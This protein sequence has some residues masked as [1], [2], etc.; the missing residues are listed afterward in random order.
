MWQEGFNPL[1]PPQTFPTYPQTVSQVPS[2]M[3]GHQIPMLDESDNR[4]IEMPDL[5]Q[6]QEQVKASACP[7][8][9]QNLPQTGG[10]DWTIVTSCD[11][12]MLVETQDID[13]LSAIIESF[14][15]AE[16]TQTEAELFP[17]PLTRKFFCILQIAVKYLLEC[18]DTLKEN[19]EESDRMNEELKTKIKKLQASLLRSKEIS[20]RNEKLKDT[21]E[22]CV[23]CGRRF[24]TIKYLDGH[25]QRRHA[26]L[27][28]AWRSLRSGELQGMEHFSE[29]LENLRQEVA[30]T[31]MELERQAQKQANKAPVTHIVSHSDEQVQLMKQL[32][33][34]QDEIIQQARDLEEK[35]MSFRKEMRNQLDDAVVALQDAQKQLDFQATRISQIPSMPPPSKEPLQPD[36]LGQSLTEQIMKPQL[37]R[38][39]KV[40]FD[41]DNLIK[42][43][44][45]LPEP[46]PALPKFDLP[47]PIKPEEQTKQDN[48]RRVQII[49]PTEPKE[50]GDTRDEEHKKILSMI[51]SGKKEENEEE[52]KQKA[53]KLASDREQLQR[54]LQQAK[55]LGEHRID[56][57]AD[58]NK[59]QAIEIIM[60]D[61]IKRVDVTLPTLKRMRQHAPL[62]VPFVRKKMDPGNKEY[63]NLYIQL[64]AF[65]GSEAPINDDYQKKLFKDRQTSFPLVPPIPKTQ[66]QA[67]AEKRKKEYAEKQLMKQQD[68]LPKIPDEI[69]SAAAKKLPYKQRISRKRPN[70]LPGDSDVEIVDRMSSEYL[71][72][73]SVGFVED[74]DYYKRMKRKQGN[75]SDDDFAEIQLSETSS[76]IEPLKGDIKVLNISQFAQEIEEEESDDNFETTKPLILTSDNKTKKI[77]VKTNGSEDFDVTKNNKITKDNLSDSDGMFNLMS[78]YSI[79]SDNESTKTIK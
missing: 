1:M 29:Q 50:S 57:D 5:G 2:Y 59:S 18:Q 21:T 44:T 15:H 28:P 60:N 19:N 34:K 67:M 3:T 6:Y 37:S 10:F 16:F 12:Q 26:D 7:R 36:E 55:Q 53:Q 78:D 41:L 51:E 35:Q 46:L 9:S 52:Q 76:G 24:K 45:P 23:V 70:L 77:S 49:E 66:R 20:K 42:D 48:G 8:S 43:V 25:I 17:N 69:L 47:S 4:N 73:A 30:R 74:P 11:P 56:P 32:V 75:Q 72:S 65:V 79:S 27:M 64:S 14:I 40:A 54:L 63:T 38:Q 31:H 39:Q 13:T 22:K 61:I 58:P 33:Q 68:G 62:S 71:S